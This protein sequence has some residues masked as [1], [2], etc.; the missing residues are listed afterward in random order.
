MKHL[1]AV[2]SFLCLAAGA[3]VES[4]R[5]APSGAPITGSVAT[6][7]P[8]RTVQIFVESDYSKAWQQFP[9]MA[10]VNEDGHFLIQIKQPGYYWL[11]AI[12]ST[13]TGSRRGACLI[14]LQQNGDARWHPL[15]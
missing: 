4:F 9:S 8:G 5:E 13:E 2:V 1:F 11:I 3:P 7:I 6:V 15:P 14:E 10:R 12:E